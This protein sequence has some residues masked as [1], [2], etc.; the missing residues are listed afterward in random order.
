MNMM[1]KEKHD[2]SCYYLNMLHVPG[3]HVVLLAEM[4]TS[5][6]GNTM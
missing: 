3:S 5:N 4:T 6:H 1:K 2:C